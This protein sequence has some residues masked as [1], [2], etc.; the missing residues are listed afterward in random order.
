MQM[1][2]GYYGNVMMLWELP[3]LWPAPDFPRAGCQSCRF[4]ECQLAGCEICS[5]P[6]L[7]IKPGA[8]AL[9]DELLTSAVHASGPN[10][11]RFSVC[12]GMLKEPWGKTHGHLMDIW[13]VVRLYIR[14]WACV[15]N[16]INGLQL[17]SLKLFLW[18]VKIIFSWLQSRPVCKAVK[19]EFGSALKSLQRVERKTKAQLKKH[20][21]KTTY[22]NLARQL[23]RLRSNSEISRIHLANLQFQAFSV[24]LYN[25][26]T[27]I[28]LWLKQEAN[29]CC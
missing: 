22:M 8:G 4:Q 20:V 26:P 23:D 7:N 6:V 24:A 1:D 21:C 17:C 12:L 28:P 29:C 14:P 16:K 25:R 13:C 3:S 19:K 10:T 2:G 5:P 11:P 15:H 27:L 9:S 18:T